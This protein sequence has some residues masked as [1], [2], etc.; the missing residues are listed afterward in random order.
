VQINERSL[1]LTAG[2]FEPTQRAEAYYT[3]PEGERNFLGYKELRVWARGIGRG[4]GE[5]GELNFYVRLGR[6]VN[7]FYLYR[8]PLNGGDTR[9]AWLP[10]IRV[11]F[12]RIIALRAQLQN[13]FL[14]GTT[15][16]T[17]SG[18]DSV[19]IA[20]TPLPAGA[21]QVYA[22][23][24]DG[25][26][27]FTVDPIA[28]APN[29][30]SVQELSVGMVRMQGGT[31]PRP[32]AAGDTLE[33]W[34]DDIRLG[35]VVDEPGFAGQIGATIIASDFADVR[36]NLTRRDAHFRQIGERPTYLASSGVDFTSAF[37]L[38][39]LLPRSFGLSIP[40]TLNYS[41]AA[42]DPLFLS[43]SDIEA[44]VVEGLRAPRSQAVSYTVQ[45][46]RAEPVGGSLLAAVL[47]NLA[48]TSSY[49]SARAQTEYQ[50]GNA[51]RLTIGLDFNVSR[52]LFPGASRWMPA[53]LYLT[54]GFT[55][56]RDE[57]EA[58][59]RPTESPLDAGQKVSGDT[60]VWRNGTVIALRPWNGVG[61]RLDFSSVRDLRDYDPSTALG[62]VGVSDR[63]SFAGLD[64]GA[65]RERAI[66][67]SLTF[68][69][70]LRGW[71][72]PRFDFSST[73][74]MVRDPNTP[75]FT[76]P[77]EAT[78]EQRV[79]RRLANTQTIT[80][81]ATLDWAAALSAAD[82]ASSFSRAL[83]RTIRPLDLTINRHV[84]SLYDAVAVSAPLSYQFAFGGA[85]AFRA[86]RGSPATAAGV[87]NQL[88]VVQELRLPLGATLTGRYQQ[89]NLRNWTRR[90][91]ES[92]AVTDGSQILFPDLALRWTGRPAALSG[93]WSNFSLTAR[94]LETEQEFATPLHAITGL[95]DDRGTLRT[96]SYPITLAAVWSA[97]P[98]LSTNVTFARTHRHEL[99]PG[100]NMRARGQEL[101]F[102]IGKEFSLPRQWELRSPLR[103]RLSYENTEGSNF[104]VNPLA[105]TNLSRV[106]DNGRR[107]WT[108][109]AD[110][111]VA[112]NLASSF[113]I[114]RVLSFDRNLDRRFTQ[115]ILS[116]VLHMQFFGGG[117]ESR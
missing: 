81:G 46:R 82:R 23:C 110:T 102:D 61:A 64:I 90:F 9:A 40:V 8:T 1:R 111:D 108:F 39:K 6:D 80:A 19:L 26:V 53:E 83:T 79:P 2:G 86:I 10:E 103:T 28:S 17:C 41:S 33:L 112:E 37:R 22:A 14:Q 67:S 115:T 35:G 30:A 95:F 48:L 76:R 55:R 27:V 34:V 114:S 92:Q 7:N 117:S 84:L 98:G 93:I 49:T 4:W 59:L 32:I 91:D 42:D 24:S 99:R 11:S 109:T 43:Q 88:T 74:S 107:A 75:F 56:A 45:I 54:T 63:A 62:V 97:I 25:Y 50:K 51:S 68:A 69:P 100:L 77:L 65:E 89:V 21:G 60:K 113:V 18:A 71:I 106:T 36:A 73:Y 85:A 3:F 94:A 70:A 29:L 104:V 47:D 16:N 38:E 101:S 5:P 105:L 44:E 72:R 87:N 13:A 96:R 52:A 15:A 12:D 58:F 57:R 116:A 78:P 31:S 66:Q 20:A